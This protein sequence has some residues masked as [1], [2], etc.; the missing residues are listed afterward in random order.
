ML[1]NCT[2]RPGIWPQL[3]SPAWETAE[4]H[5]Y[6]LCLVRI[7]LL[8]RQ[9]IPLL[10]FLIVSLQLPHPCVPHGYWLWCMECLKGGN[11]TFS[12]QRHLQNG[13]LS[14][15]TMPQP[16]MHNTEKAMWTVKCPIFLWN[17]QP[18][19]TYTSHGINRVKSFWDCMKSH[20]IYHGYCFPRNSHVENIITSFK[21]GVNFLLT[22][23]AT[24]F[25]S[26]P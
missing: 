15:D 20:P 7:Q 19:P 18:P 11:R 26:Q 8:S 1:S 25:Y 21:L 23:R 2:Y 10:S 4:G 5:L 17:P 24:H 13:S 9:R 16:D 14:P 6:P 3:S 12:Y 22:F